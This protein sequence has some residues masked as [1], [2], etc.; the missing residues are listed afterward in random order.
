M[1]VRP[2]RGLVVEEQYLNNLEKALIIFG[3]SPV[4]GKVKTRLAEEIGDIQ[5][6]NIYRQLLFYTFDMADE[7]NAYVVACLP[8]KDDHVLE[9]VPYSTY[10]Q[11]VHGD[12]GDKLRLASKELFNRGFEKV[13][14]IGSDCADISSKHIQIAYD[15]LDTHDIV[16]GPAEDGGYYLI[17]MT[18][19]SPYLFTNKSWSTKQLLDETLE[20]IK[21]V[22]NTVFML[23]KLSDIDYLSDLEKTKNR[24]IKWDQRT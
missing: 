4:P 5:A 6:C 9:A 11:Q 20:S 15:K 16:I 12:L 7:C 13:I 21:E 18:E 24:R 2:V 17:G 22:D 19:P 14:C 10:L 8:E 23:E 3:K 1:A